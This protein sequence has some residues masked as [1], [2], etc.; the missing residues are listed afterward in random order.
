[1][2]V[3]K[4]TKIF[5]ISMKKLFAIITLLVC[6]N[7]I[8]QN[9]GLKYLGKSTDDKK[10]QRPLDLFVKQLALAQRFE[11]KFALRESMAELLKDVSSVNPTI[12][13][14]AVTNNIVNL[15][16]VTIILNAVQ[17]IS[18][19]ANVLSDLMYKSSFKW[20]KDI[21]LLLGLT[22]RDFRKHSK[23]L[24]DIRTIFPRFKWVVVP[25]KGLSKT[26]LYILENGEVTKIIFLARSLRYLDK[27]FDIKEFLKPLR[28]NNCHVIGGSSVYPDETWQ[29]GCYQSKLIWSQYKVQ[30]GFDATY[31]RNLV[32]CDTIDGPFATHTDLMRDFLQ[33][34]WKVRYSYWD[35][36]LHLFKGAPNTDLVYIEFMY[37]VKK[38]NKIILI[39]P[40]S[41]FKTNDTRFWLNTSRDQWKEFVVKHEIGEIMISEGEDQ[42]LH[43]EFTY[44]EAE[45][46]CE[47]HDDMLPPRPCIMDLHNMLINSYK[48]FDR[49]G[50]G[51]TNEDGSALG[52]TKF[53]TTIPWDLDQDF[54]FRTSDFTELLK[55]EAEFN[56]IG[57]KFDTKK[58]D[59]PC[60]RGL[61]HAKSWSCGYMSLYDVNWYL[62][63]WG[64]YLLISDFYRP[65]LVP[66]K[67]RN[68]LEWY[69]RSKANVT[70]VK[71]GDH[72]TVSRSN[73]GVYSRS[74]YGSNFLRHVKHWSKHLENSYSDYI[75]HGR[76]FPECPYEGHHLC[77]NQYLADGNIQFQRV[78]A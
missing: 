41:I 60:A 16:D 44:T 15:D 22:S 58:L 67:F 34:R 25:G 54:A 23:M 48:L 52:A 6:I 26:L 24:N 73:P 59:V 69:W 64:Q 56:K 74:R 3:K 47:Y 31:G 46:K 75:M 71:M 66:D 4:I 7:I 68:S 38:K 65:D 51:Y 77:M 61:S 17:E 29:L 37:F 33:T 21:N 35:H 1:M 27:N 10:M 43:H 40:E 63:A 9:C 76:R 50:L 45:S 78:W 49:Y 19:I 70:L 28:R 57:I 30:Q 11:R 2:V 72:W 42:G 20:I 55:H 36:F 39:H 12:K 32:R 18:D 14:Q 62:E 8:I 13:I 5:Q 53:G